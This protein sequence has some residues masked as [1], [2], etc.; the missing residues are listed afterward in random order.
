MSTTAQ[1][2]DI[3]WILICAALVMLMQAGFSCLE[4]G[5]VRTK[6]SINVAS[7]NFADFCLSSVLFWLFGFALMFGATAD[8][9]FGT[10]GFLFGDTAN[11]WMMAFFIFQLGFCGTATTIVSGAVA[12]RMRFSGYLVAATIISAVIYP[13]IGHWAWGS[14]AGAAPGGWLEQMGFIDFAGSTVVHSVGGWIGLAAIIIIGP[15]IGRFGEN[16]V[17]IH[18]HDLPLVTLGVFLLWFGWFGFNGGSTLGLTP[19]VPVIIVN[20]T[21]SGAFGGVVGLAL[22]W[23]ISGRPDVAMI[24]NGALAGLVG[25]TASA[26]IMTPLAAAGIGSIAAVVMY[27]VTMLLER[28]EIDDVVGAVPVHLAAGSWGTLAVAIFSDPAG[29][30]TGLSR[31]EQLGVQ[32]TGVGATF[33]W[34]FGVGFALLWLMN[35]WLCQWRSKKGPPRRCKKGPLGGCGLVPVVH[36]RA[37]RATRRALNR[38]T[39]RRARE[40]PVGPRGQ[41]WAGWSVQLAVGV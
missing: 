17:P 7:K 28:L 41:A 8:G 36:G 24:M 2:L 13:V 33:V 30:G 18:G 15:R 25:I 23:R 39:R 32:A 40:G 11:P 9:W 6:N 14:L 37:P 16:A 10:S 29:W 31:W 12:E 27:A 35:R 26:H 4:S 34:A 21:V 20:T 1:H 22:A 38:P 3:A 5:L 19:E